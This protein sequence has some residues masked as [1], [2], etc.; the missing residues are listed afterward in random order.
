MLGLHP[1]SEHFKHFFMPKIMFS[2]VITESKIDGNQTENKSGNS[3]RIVRFENL[4]NWR[5]LDTMSKVAITVAGSLLVMVCS[6]IGVWLALRHR[7]LKVLGIHSQIKRHRPYKPNTMDNSVGS[8]NP[9][10]FNHNHMTGGEPGLR[11]LMDFTYS[12]SGSGLPLLVQRSIARQIQL[13]EVIGKGKYGEVWRSK[14]RGENVAVKIF[15]SRD[16]KSWI[17]EV[18]IYQ[19]VSLRHENI[20]GFIA[21]DNKGKSHSLRD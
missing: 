9:L 13:Q 14:W 6:A 3:S 1:F 19:T 18:E 15:N 2:S 21:A 4:L 17:R 12:G 8:V 7:Q 5:Q 10:L 11:D 16:E 20:L